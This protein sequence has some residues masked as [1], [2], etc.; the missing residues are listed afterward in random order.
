MEARFFKKAVVLTG[1]GCNS[2][3]I[4]CLQST[5]TPAFFSKERIM[6]Q[7]V[8][9][10][11]RGA[12][13]LVIT[14]GE[15]SIHKNFLDFIRFA[16]VLG[17]E[18]IQTVSNGRMFS[19]KNFVRKVAIAGLTETT[20]SFHGAT[21]EKHDALT[22]TPGSF[23]EAS[24]AAVNC[25][26]QGIL[27]SFNTAV[28]SLN[29]LDLGD[30]VKFIHNDLKFEKF[31]YDIVGTSPNGRAWDHKLLPKHEDVKE[32]L[33]RAF[34]YA[35]KHNI[36]VWVT[37]TPIQDFPPGYEYH[38]E[39]WEVI[40][41]DVIAMWPIGWREDRVCDPLK[42]EYCE[43]GPFCDHIKL[44]RSRMGAAKLS[45]VTGSAVP[46]KLAGAL[47]FSGKFLVED[48]KDAPVVEKHGFTPFARV[49]F[50]GIGFGLE[51]AI[52]KLEAADSAGVKSE[53][54]FRVNR[55]SIDSLDE[56]KGI[57]LVF[58]P[59]N[60][61]PYVKYHFDK[62]NRLVETTGALMA[63]EDVLGSVKGD[64]M[65]VPL[66]I[67]KGR[68]K[69]YWVNLDD[70]SDELEV[71]PRNFTTRLVTDIR[72]YPWDC[73]N[74]PLKSKCPGFFGDYVKLFGFD[75]VSPFPDTR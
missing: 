4:F 9:E 63:L 37:R 2:N 1:F 14:G 17:Y 62:S 32:G 16:K 46:G 23:K 59:T 69:E 50:D 74:C 45:Y 70:F 48:I 7:I 25:R 71:K 21:A 64:W 57:N 36:V 60:P 39:P 58:S 26:D 31:D 11:L 19:S 40:T 20:I 35:E 47:K 42:C 43:G 34:E 44:L 56:L 52:K 29:A 18:R 5:R 61:Y 55:K 10:R 41:H 28:S 54:E 22:R 72:V 53:L 13:W 49:I 6:K 15:S 65:N 8:E 24:R 75:K 51:Q 68:E 73:Q 27:L 33:K 67:Y 30:I 3:C 38:K 66:C 12:N